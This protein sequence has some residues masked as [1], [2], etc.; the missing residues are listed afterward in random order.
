MTVPLSAMTTEYTQ[1]GPLLELCGISEED[2]RHQFEEW[3][4]LG[5]FIYAF[6]KFRPQNSLDDVERYRM[7]WKAS[8]SFRVI[9]TQIGFFFPALPVLTGCVI[10]SLYIHIE[11]VSR[12]HL[13][14]KLQDAS[15]PVL[16]S[17]VLLDKGSA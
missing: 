1:K 4:R 10:C 7:A 16:P 11:H 5:D 6:L 14:S 8:S 2:V 13:K 17:S 3:A 12:I 15:V 9:S